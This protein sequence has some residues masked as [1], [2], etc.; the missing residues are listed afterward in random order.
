MQLLSQFDPLN[1]YFDQAGSQHI[2]SHYSYV[3][4]YRLTPH[5]V[6]GGA[7]LRGYPLQYQHGKHAWT[8]NLEIRRYSDSV[9][10]K[11]FAVGWT[12]FFDAGKAWDDFNE[13]QYNSIPHQ[14]LESKT[15]YSFGLGARFYSLVSNGTNILHLDLVKPISDNV[16]LDGW[17][18]RVSAKKAF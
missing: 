12:F 17:E 16:E 5:S 1:F 10:F 18:W 11:S 7:Y 14:N 8:R 2:G 9:I 3:N 15:L 4:Q 13:E 6:G